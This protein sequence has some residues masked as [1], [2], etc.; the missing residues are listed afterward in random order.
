CIVRRGG[1]PVSAVYTVLWVRPQR[2]RQQLSPKLHAVKADGRA[3]F[4]R[5]PAF[6][7]ERDPAD[8]FDI[9]R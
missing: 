8:S 7:A 2:S 5:P 3:I 4:A 9:F 1:V 6:Y